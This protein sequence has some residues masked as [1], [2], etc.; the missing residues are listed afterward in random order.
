MAVTNDGALFERFVVPPFSVLDASQGYWQDRRRLWKSLGIESEVGREQ[1]LTYN[2]KSDDFL[3][4]KL[5]EQGTTSIFDPVMCELMYRW[6][7]PNDGTILDPFCGGSVR[8]IVAGKLGRSYTGIDL[9]PEQVAEN[10]SQLRT[11]CPD[12][13][14]T[15]H[16]GDS[17]TLPTMTNI[18]TDYDFVFSC[19]PY[20]DLEKYSDSPNDLSNMEHKDFI[21]AYTQIIKHSVDRLKPN[22]F[23]CFVVGNYR[24][25]DGSLYD[26]SGETVKAFEAAGAKLYNNF[27]LVVSVNTLSLR[28]SRQFVASRKAGMR[29]QVALVFLKGDEKL[30][31][32]AIGDVDPTY[33]GG[34]FARQGETSVLDMFT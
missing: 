7:T 8:G 4:G 9:R 25:A 19:P 17:T 20:G 29:H 27:I 23:G 2:G 15:Y 32:K 33:P 24:L 13:K 21:Q 22:R 18:P 1:N 16:C 26:F 6:F 34:V 11:I 5:T 12:G 3:S 30:A 28:V 10:Q 31:T 14:V